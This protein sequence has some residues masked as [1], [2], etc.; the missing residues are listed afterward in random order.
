[1]SHILRLMDI[2]NNFCLNLDCQFLSYDKQN[3]NLKN[4]P[5]SVEIAETIELVHVCDGVKFPK[6]I[7]S[8][9]LKL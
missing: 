7:S 8:F 5:E 1:M 4:P 3:T 6:M 9:C 2:I